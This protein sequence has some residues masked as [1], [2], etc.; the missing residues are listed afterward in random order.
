MEPI[1]PPA[2]ARLR[3]CNDMLMHLA[4]IYSNNKQNG[5]I[6]D[7]NILVQSDV[8]VK[9]KICQNNLVWV[10]PNGSKSVRQAWETDT[11]SSCA[12]T[13]NW[14][15][16]RAAPI[17]ILEVTSPYGAGHMVQAVDARG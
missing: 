16:L 3:L 12:E 5:I 1:T 8:H 4:W 13:C 6:S 7:T 15:I 2:T 17:P 11:S 9:H 14:R 10:S